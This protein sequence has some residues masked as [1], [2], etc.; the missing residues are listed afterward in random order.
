MSACSRPA[1]EWPPEAAAA[2]E[3]AAGSGSPQKGSSW[4]QILPR[5][6]PVERQVA[7][8]CCCAVGE[9]RRRGVVVRHGVRHGLYYRYI[10]LLYSLSADTSQHADVCLFVGLN[11]S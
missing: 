8:S 1:P 6:S 5:G 10:V 7:G 3:T 2:S 11:I 9:V 4:R